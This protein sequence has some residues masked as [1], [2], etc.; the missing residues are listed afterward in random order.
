MISQLARL[1]NAETGRLPLWDQK[2]S[3]RRLI[4]EHDQDPRS[5]NLGFRHIAFTEGEKVFPSFAALVTDAP[6]PAEARGEAFAA[7]GM[8]ISGD[9]RPGTWLVGGWVD[10]KRVRHITS[11]SVMRGPWTAQQAL[12]RLAQLDAA[13]DPAVIVVEDNAAQAAYL[14][15]ARV[16]PDRYPFWSKLKGHTTT[17]SNKSDRAVGL[18]GLEIQF[19]NGGWVIHRTGEHRADCRCEMCELVRQFDQYPNGEHDDAV[20]ALWKLE[21]AFSRLSRKPPAEPDPDR[22]AAEIEAQERRVQE[23]MERLDRGEAPLP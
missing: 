15:I 11:D 2:W 6:F 5:F 19:A 10:S 9:G 1:P 23:I 3:A 21:H 20:M 14:D 17:G 12:D 16:A 22:V 4:T 7:V 13:I 18:P 8:D